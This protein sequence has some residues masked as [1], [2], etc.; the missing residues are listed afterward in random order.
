M[1]WASI[2]AWCSG[3]ARTASRPPW[4]AGCSVL[5]RPSII[6]GKPVRSRH[7]LRPAGPASASALLRAAGRD[8]VD[9]ALAQRAGE[10]DEAGLVG[11]GQQGARDALQ[12]ARHPAAPLGGRA[13]RGSMNGAA[14]VERVT[15][16]L[17]APPRFDS[18]TRSK[19]QRTPGVW[20]ALESQ[21]RS[22]ACAGRC[23]WPRRTRSPRSRAAT[24]LASNRQASP[25]GSASTIEPPSSA[26]LARDAGVKVEADRHVV[27]AEASAP[28]RMKASSPSRRLPSGESR[29]V[30]RAMRPKRAR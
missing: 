30:R 14:G 22:A 25:S 20:L 15:R 18:V 8:E 17:T 3:F 26:G 1:P 5:T 13:P 6:S 7:V 11:D 24:G 4:T 23:R 29:Q 16:P 9:A 10:V 12:I 28:S 27:G 2:A 19:R 21:A